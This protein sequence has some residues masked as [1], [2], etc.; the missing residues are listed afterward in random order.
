MSLIEVLITTINHTLY[1]ARNKGTKVNIA[2]QNA[3]LKIVSFLYGV[4]DF[5]TILYY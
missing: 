5:M 1:S 2:Y 4:C 3:I